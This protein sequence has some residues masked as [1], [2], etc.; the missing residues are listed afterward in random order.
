[1]SYCDCLA[2][3]LPENVTGAGSIV[4]EVIFHQTGLVRQVWN[5][6][7]QC[8]ALKIYLAKQPSLLGRVNLLTYLPYALALPL[9][10][11]KK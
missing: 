7:I 3:K 6:P 4:Q 2:K 1:M 5:W 8:T 11:N 10:G 9:Q